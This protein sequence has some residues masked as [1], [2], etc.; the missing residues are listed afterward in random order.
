[1]LNTLGFIAMT[2]LIA[3]AAMVVLLSLLSR[4]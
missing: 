3:V 2:G 4:V 1:M